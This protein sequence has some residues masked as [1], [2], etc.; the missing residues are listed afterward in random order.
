MGLLVDFPLLSPALGFENHIWTEEAETPI[1]S[2][3]DSGLRHRPGSDI[4]E[5]PA[6]FL[7]PVSFSKSQFFYEA[8]GLVPVLL[9]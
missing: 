2:G 1:P 9:T 6:L 5:L 7:C 4:A 8:S 3:Q